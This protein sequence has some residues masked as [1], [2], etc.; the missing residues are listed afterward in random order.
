M[1]CSPTDSLD[2]HPQRL[3][4]LLPLLRLLPEELQAPA[5]Q[6]QE[7]IHQQSS[8]QQRHIRIVDQAGPVHP[9]HNCLGVC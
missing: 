5:Q 7:V 8:I 2:L 1:R 6:A 3:G 4:G 9:S